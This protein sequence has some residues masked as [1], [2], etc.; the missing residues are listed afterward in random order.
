MGSFSHLVRFELVGNGLQVKVVQEN[1]FGFFESI[2]PL[3]DSS[4]E[5]IG[6]SKLHH[7][8]V[9]CTILDGCEACVVLRSVSGKSQIGET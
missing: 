5:P 9:L 3:G 4:L 6:S 1:K 2:K 7:S 8:L